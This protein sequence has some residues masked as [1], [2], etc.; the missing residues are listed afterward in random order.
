LQTPANYNLALFVLMMIR[1][2]CI[3]VVRSVSL[4]LPSSPVHKLVLKDETLSVILSA[5]FLG[6]R[7]TFEPYQPGF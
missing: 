6:K 2:V 3:M 5:S 4:F 7:N 1:S